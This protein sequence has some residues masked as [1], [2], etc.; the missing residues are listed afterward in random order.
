MALRA[1]VASRGFGKLGVAERS[2]VALS[3]HPRCQI[4]AA[5]GA[6]VCGVGSFLEGCGGVGACLG[7]GGDQRAG[8]VLP[9]AGS[10]RLAAATCWRRRC[11][12]KWRAPRVALCGLRV[13]DATVIHGP[14][15]KGTEWRAHVLMDPGSGGFRAVELTDARGGEGYGR[16]RV[17]AQEVIL[18]DRAYATA[19][20]LWAVHS[21]HAYVVA[22]LNPHTIRVCDEQRKRLSLRDK[23]REV[24]Q[25]GGVE[26]NILVPIPPEKRTKTRKWGLRRAIAWVPARAV[27][28]RTRD[29]SVIWLLTTLSAA[30]SLRCATD[31]ALPLALAD[32]VVFQAAEVVAAFRCARLPA[33]DPP[34]NPGCWPASWRPT[35]TA[36]GGSTPPSM[37]T[38]DPSGISLMN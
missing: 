9:V 25:I 4:L 19:R 24:P 5:P 2:S 8:V 21:A 35:K 22:R 10:R 36:L 23:E 3:P 12:A 16:Y 31:A 32:R 18:G 1:Y 11:K 29:G 14:G 13:V 15:A 38:I 37:E 34:P 33:G 7:G 30:T 27:A 28:A 6:G 20:G 26:F 17:S